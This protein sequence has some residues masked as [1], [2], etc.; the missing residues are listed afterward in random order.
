MALSAGSEIVWLEIDFLA[1][2]MD[3]GGMDCQCLYYIMV[4]Q[5][6]RLDLRTAQ[7]EQVLILD[8]AIVGVTGIAVE[9]DGNQ[10]KAASHPCL[11]I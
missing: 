1:T 5:L 8:S 4:N 9:A 11:Y 10:T 7:E 2:Q 6:W 3:V